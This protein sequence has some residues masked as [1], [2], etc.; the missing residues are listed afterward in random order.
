MC[1]ID[2]VFD[3]SN[4]IKFIQ[5]L[6]IKNRG[7]IK[8]KMSKKTGK[9]MEYE[10]KAVRTFWSPAMLEILQ[11][12]FPTTYNE[13]LAGVLGVQVRVMQRKARELGLKKD[14]D[15]VRAVHIECAKWGHTKSKQLGYPW[16]WK[17][18]GRENPGTPYRKGRVVSEETKKKISDS[19]RR[20][21]TAHPTLARETSL[22]AA[23][24]K[25]RKKEQTN[26]MIEYGKD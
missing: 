26:N 14:K 18:M 6:F 7:M 22:K 25:K 10:G 13:E 24:T 4:S 2:S 23:E 9:L 19:C 16:S 3:I 17:K 20:F 5:D 12:M 21:W 11:R 8:V 1:Y 15:W